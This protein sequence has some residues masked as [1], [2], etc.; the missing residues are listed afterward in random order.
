MRLVLARRF[1]PRDSSASAFQRDAIPTLIEADSL[2]IP[3]WAGFCFTMVDTTN[4]FHEGGDTTLI[5]LE[6][7]RLAYQGTLVAGCGTEAAPA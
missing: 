5:G 1:S 4:V 6:K 2:G 7:R 3:I